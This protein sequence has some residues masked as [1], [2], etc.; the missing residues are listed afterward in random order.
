MSSA[1]AVK[2][3]AFPSTGLT[4]LIITQWLETGIDPL[5]T[6][7]LDGGACVDVERCAGNMPLRSPGT[8]RKSERG[9][10]CRDAPGHMC[11][12]ICTAESV[13]LLTR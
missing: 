8:E 4:Y 13:S 12:V 10:L 7:H 5:E 9:S 3:I 1:S 2:L 11:H 6:V